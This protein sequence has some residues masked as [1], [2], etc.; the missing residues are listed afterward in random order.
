MLCRILNSNLEQFF[1]RTLELYMPANMEVYEEGELL[2]P[3]RVKCYNAINNI[4]GTIGGITE[5]TLIHTTMD[6]TATSMS[7]GSSMAGRYEIN[8]INVMAEGVLQLTGDIASELTL[9]SGTL[10]IAPTGVLK[11][12]QLTLTADNIRIE[13]GGTIDLDEMG[14]GTDGTGN[15]LICNSYWAST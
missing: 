8:S 13:E 9:S 6:L 4:H 14:Y 10:H 5:L 12:K 11:A 2:L 1:F 3:G 7:Q 15:N